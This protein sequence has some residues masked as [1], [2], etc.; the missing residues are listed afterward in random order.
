[1][2]QQIPAGFL[3]CTRAGHTECTHM[4]AQRHI[5]NDLLDAL[6][7][8]QNISLRIDLAQQLHFRD[9]QCIFQTDILTEV[10]HMHA[11]SSCESTGKRTSA[12]ACPHCLGHA[13][14]FFRVHDNIGSERNVNIFLNGTN[15]TGH[16]H[17]CLGMADISHREA[18]LVGNEHT[19]HAALL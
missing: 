5:I 7:C 11:I 3:S 14:R 4:I 8:Q 12:E 13:D 6:L 18:E 19:V 15:D 16:G 2:C 1:M 10:I 9:A 17:Q